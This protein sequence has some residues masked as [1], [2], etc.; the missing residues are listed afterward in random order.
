MIYKF[1]KKSS[2]HLIILLHGTGGDESSLLEIGEMINAD[3]SLLGLK[4]NVN[5]NGM[6]RFFKRVRPG[7]FDLDDLV[8]ETHSI[9]TFLDDFLEKNG[10]DYANTIIIGYSNGANMIA[11][12]IFHYGGIF[13]GV[14]LL[15]PMVPIKGFKVKNQKTQNIFI[16]ASKTDRIVNAE[17]PVIL[18][19]MLEDAHAKVKLNWYNY[20]HSICEEELSDLYHWVIKL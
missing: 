20:G 13:K 14:A 4:G 5:E 3:A 18:N 12:L 1:I 16:S 11:S 10:F 8:Y 19:K 15:H 7:V 6:N 17:E 2:S 9:K